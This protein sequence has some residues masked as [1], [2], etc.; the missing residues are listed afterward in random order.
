MRGRALSCGDV[1]LNSGG[2][3]PPSAVAV[4]HGAPAAALL[5]SE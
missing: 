1:T 3:W 5:L 2:T 4:E